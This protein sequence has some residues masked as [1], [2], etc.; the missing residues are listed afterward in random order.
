M[1]KRTDNEILSEIQGCYMD[2]S[3]ENLSCDG[4]RSF[5]QTQ[6]AEFKIRSRLKELFKELGREVNESQA[7]GR[8]SDEDIDRAL[9]TVPGGF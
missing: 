8:E 3:P 1:I 2:L 7:Y 9:D 5:S 6:T 4:E